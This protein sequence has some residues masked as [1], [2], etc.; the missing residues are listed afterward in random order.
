MRRAKAALR[1]D[2]DYFLH[3]V[4]GVI[5]VGANSGQE[6]NR[7]KHHDLRVV[8][9]EPIPEVFA[10]LVA[11]LHGYSNQIA[12]QHLVTD[13]DDAEYEFH[14]SNNSGKSSSILE[15]K[16]HRDIWPEVAYDRTITLRSTTLVSLLKN[17]RI[18]IGDYDA[19]ILDTQGSERL[20][21]EGAAPVLHA[22]RFIKTEIPDFE[23]YAGCCQLKDIDAFVT[24]Y[25]FQEVSR[26]RFAERSESEGYYDVVYERK[27]SLLSGKPQ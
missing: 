21:L 23:S 25:G 14:V 15:L 18:N 20:V 27:V 8:W 6:R 1:K 4:S 16:L 26:H 7:Y 5:H 24:Q 13:Q 19:L 10:A 12:F 17:E 9:I 3:C 22:F 11:N 2:P